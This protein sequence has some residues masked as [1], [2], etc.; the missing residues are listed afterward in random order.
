MA[1]QAGA[2]SWR[3]FFRDND[4]VY[5]DGSDPD[6]LCAEQA[7][8][9][10]WFCERV[11]GDKVVAALREQQ[12]VIFEGDDLRPG[13]A[14]QWKADTEFRAVWILADDAAGL[15]ERMRVKTGLSDGRLEV[16]TEVHVL[17][18]DLLR[19]EASEAGFPFV[20]ADPVSTL[21]DRTWQA[22]SAG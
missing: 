9:S 17:Y 19:T 18:S 15:R 8:L 22:L 4:P 1:G 2:S 16:Q 12:P 6:E 14:A 7:H 13:W 11:V 5:L 3:R 20:S 21:A 10:S